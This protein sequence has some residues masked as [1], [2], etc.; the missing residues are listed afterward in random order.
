MLDP[1][2]YSQ[3]NKFTREGTVAALNKMGHLIKWKPGNRDT[4]LDIGCG[5]ANVLVDAILPTF[6]GQYSKCFATDVSEKMVESARKMHGHRKDLEFL[7]L[8]IM[9]VSEFL[10]E[11]GPVDHICSS[12][13]LHWVPDQAA[14][15]KNIF[16]TLKPGGDFFSV[17]VNDTEVFEIYVHMNEN[18]KWNHYFDN[19][20]Q[21]VPKSQYS[22]Q[23]EEDLRDMLVKCGFADIVVEMLRKRVPFEDRAHLAKLLSE[24]MAQTKNIPEEKREEYFQDAI[25]FG[26]KSGNFV[27]EENGVITVSLNL[28]IAYAKRPE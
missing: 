9:N 5:P 28:I 6:K 25:D 10:L 23:P 14:A 7:Q 22:K 1:D 11:H 13:V 24:V 4:V 27:A 26:L 2:N 16:Q 15:F 19:L 21:Y 12:F 17:H 8:D 20:L 18:V 3:L